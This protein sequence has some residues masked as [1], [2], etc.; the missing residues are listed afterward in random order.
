MTDSHGA[1]L[2]EIRPNVE[3]HSFDYIPRAERHGKAWHQFTFWFSGNAELT[4]LA[5]GLIGITLGLS[6][7]WD[8]VAVVIG[9][10]FGTLFMASHSVQGPRL[11]I[12]QMIQ[13]RPQFGYFGSLLPQG[14][15]VLLYIGFNVFNTLIAGQ[16]LA[17]LTP[18]DA[19][20]ATILSFLAALVIA[21]GGYDWLHFCTRWCTWLFLVCFGIFT[22]GVLF[23]V[24]LPATASSGGFKLT[25]FMIVLLAVAAYVVSE[26]PYVS[27]FSRYLSPRVSSR[28]CFWW[29]YAG[30]AL[31]SLW[32]IGLG[33]FLLSAMPKA[34]TVSVI[35]LGGDTIF[36][37]FGTI[38]LII[39]FAMLVVVTATNMYGGSVTAITVAT[40]AK[41][42]VSTRKVRLAGVLF[43]GIVATALALTLP[44]N[45]LT[46][47]GTFLTV[48]LYVL[49]P[50]TAV[51]LTDYYVVRKGRYAVTEI[52]KRDGIYGL[53]QWRGLVAYAVGFVAMIP[54]F[55]TQWYTGPLVSKL[56]GG[57]FSIF[58]GLPVSAIVY[59][60]LARNHDL[61]RERELA[62][63]ESIEPATRA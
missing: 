32:M 51:N 36:K 58:I 22:V 27:D 42:I 24:H 46:D 30:S 4:T 9:L 50:W 63:T 28:A 48:L 35:Q 16:A 33:S 12:P 56:G 6:L 10:A 45:F 39:A 2:S 34:N 3:T 17:A 25:A 21:Y 23:T 53:W 62:A 61:S 13:S 60:L 52:F 1:A 59:Y 19:K 55:A 26:A 29:T 18:L 5:V 11:G 41:D 37:G 54:F 31:G 38:S 57:D 15:V 40:T 20:T 49:I 7:F 43:I 47:Y 8:L 14:V 44:D